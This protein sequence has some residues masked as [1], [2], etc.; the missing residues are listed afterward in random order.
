MEDRVLLEWHFTPK[1][2]FEDEIRSDYSDYKMIIKNGIVEAR[3]NHENYD[4]RHK[5]LASLH[6]GLNT[7]FLAVQ[8]LTHK[9]HELSKGSMCRL[10]PLKIGKILP[11]KIGTFLIGIQLTINLNTIDIAILNWQH[12]TIC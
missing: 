7:I 5:I 8:V 9:P 10:H 1:D 2:Y 3:I 12:L 4:E 11:K 6:Q